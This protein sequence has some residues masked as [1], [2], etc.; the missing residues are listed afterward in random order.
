MEEPTLKLV[1][2]LGSVSSIILII[3]VLKK[4][5]KG[6]HTPSKEREQDINNLKNTIQEMQENLEK[7]KK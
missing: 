5:L 2:F 7:I 1:D 4:A 6:L 3:F